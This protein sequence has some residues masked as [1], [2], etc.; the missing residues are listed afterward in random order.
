MST[1][2]FRRLP[3]LPRRP[4]YGPSDLKG[5]ILGGMVAGAVVLPMSMGYGVL[6]GLGAAAGLHG[7]VAVGIFASLFGGTRG[8]VYGP[9]VAVAVT[10]SVV[11]AE[12]A[13]S[14]AEAA[15]IGILAGL[16]QI[17]FGLLGLGRYTSYIPS[18]LTSGFLTAF[19][20]LVITKQMFFA[21]GGVPLR[22]SVMENV[23]ALPGA[24]AAAN[25]SAVALTLACVAVSLL[26]RG[27]LLKLLPAPFAVLVLSVLAGMFIFKDAPTVG[28]IPGGLLVLE[29]SA[30]SLGFFVKAAQPAFVMALLGS[31]S[32]FAMALR[33]D[34]ITGTQCRPNREMLAQGL[35]NIAAGMTGGL[36]G[37][38]AA[39]SIA[40]ALAGGRSPVAGLTVVGIVLAAILFLG[41]VAARVPFAALA[42]VL[43]VTAFSLIDWRFIRRIHLI[44]RS[45]ATVM[46]LTC[47]LVLFVDLAT[48]IVICLVAAALTGSRRLEDLETTA[49]VSV[50]LLDRA[51][52]GPDQGDADPFAAN[53]GLVVF[54]DRVTVASAKE[55][56]RILR[57]DISGHQ[58]TIFDMSRTVYIDDSAAVAIGDLVSLAAA[59]RTR[60]VIIIAAYAGKRGQR[61]AGDGLAPGG[62]RGTP[63]PG[64]GRGQ[65]HSRRYHQEQG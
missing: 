18:S 20:I 64:R 17:A 36:A 11:V 62:A 6:S 33:V 49:L 35:G 2:A 43:F 31:I 3:R 1:T 52:L 60:T 22:G 40:N 48:A 24:F 29:V 26:W 56:S 58:I 55:L 51:V 37:S 34:S 9:Q 54:P 50:P 8:L 5:D 46:L 4:E 7:A 63:G 53:T 30:V 19:G 21:L 10:M 12:Y 59:G 57:P 16:M 23:A 32:T 47:G 14:L 42:A 44:P 15:T 65:A 61:D 39:G 13:G 27:R 38:M 45:Y 25:P 41:P 28:E